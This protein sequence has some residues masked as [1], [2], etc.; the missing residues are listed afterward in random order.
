M[1]W[2]A[3]FENFKLLNDP[4]L[5]IHINVNRKND[6]VFYKMTETFVRMIDDDDK[7]P[8][9]EKKNETPHQLIDKHR[10]PLYARHSI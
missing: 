5:R 3:S 2:Y 4:T 6:A 10:I 7:F 1:N 9:I 8:R